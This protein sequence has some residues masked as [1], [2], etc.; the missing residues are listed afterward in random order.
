MNAVIDLGGPQILS[1]DEVVGVYSSVLNKKV[2][3]IHVPAFILRMNQLIMGVVS[4][5]AGNIL[6][7]NWYAANYDT[8]YEMGPTAAA[9]D[10]QLTSVEQFL[11]G[12]LSALPGGP[13]RSLQ[14]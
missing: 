2:R 9:F 8:A 3:I 7:L 14:S 5:A 10:V 1:W 13:G 4:P 12:K 11:R 6:G